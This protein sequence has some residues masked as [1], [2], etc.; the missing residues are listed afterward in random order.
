MDYVPHDERHG[1]S[2]GRWFWTILAILAIGFLLN[3]VVGHAAPMCSVDPS[4]RVSQPPL[5]YL[6]TKVTIEPDEH[7]TVA[8]LA[9]VGL[10]GMERSSVIDTDVKTQWIRWQLEPMSA[11]EYVVV[12]DVWNEVP[13]IVCHAESRVIVGTSPDESSRSESSRP[14][15][16]PPQ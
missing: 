10:A 9:L 14:D 1:I 3:A 13:T 6:Q 11:G 16:V 8:R 4:P 15:R 12:L 5:R 2:S 7:L